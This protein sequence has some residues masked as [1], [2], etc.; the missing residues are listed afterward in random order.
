[1]IAAS[2]PGPRD[3]RDLSGFSCEL[4]TR[5]D[6]LLISRELGL[7]SST[8][9]FIRSLLPDFHR[10]KLQAA[11]SETLEDLGIMWSYS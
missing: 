3:P 1:M 11:D 2:F 9:D 7:S 4:L 8:A 10:L 6:Q 5:L